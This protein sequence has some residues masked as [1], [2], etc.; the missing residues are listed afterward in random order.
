MAPSLLTIPQELRNE[1][2]SLLPEITT[3]SLPSS[4]L[5]VDGQTPRALKEALLADPAITRVNKQLRSEIDKSALRQHIE[6]RVE[7]PDDTQKID[8][9]L[10]R[11]PSSVIERINTITLRFNTPGAKKI[12]IGP[13]RLSS[14]DEFGE[15]QLI[16][17]TTPSCIIIAK[18]TLTLHEESRA[19]LLPDPRFFRTEEKRIVECL[20]QKLPRHSTQ[21]HRMF[22]AG[23]FSVVVSD[24]LVSMKDLSLRTDVDVYHHIRKLNFDLYALALKRRRERIQAANKALMGYTDDCELGS[25]AVCVTGGSWRSGCNRD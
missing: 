21:D 22:V 24:F 2:Y 9:W 16:L 14:R 3:I 15:I 23:P 19:V 10:S 6:I 20:K 12:L 11:L 5:R 7:D 17:S 25:P 8:D 18:P 1:I 13:G 4:A